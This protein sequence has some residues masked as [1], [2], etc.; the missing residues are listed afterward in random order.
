MSS[1]TA[2]LESSQ[3]TTLFAHARRVTRISLGFAGLS[4]LALGCSSASTEDAENTSSALGTIVPMGVS[5][6]TLS[7]ESPAGQITNGNGGCLDLP[8]GNT[9][10]GT[11]L[12]IWQCNGNGLHQSWFVD[13]AGSIHYGGNPFKCIDFPAQDLVNGI[14]IN[15]TQ[16]QIWDCNG[17]AGPDQ[18]WRVGT[19]N[20]IQFANDLNKCVELRNGNSI[21]DTPVQVYDCNGTRGQSWK[22]VQGGPVEAF[23]LKNGNGGCLDLPGGVTTNGTLLQLWACDANGD[24]QSWYMDGKSALHFALYPSK[25]VDFP[26]QA[27]NNGY[28]LPLSQLQLWDCNGGTGPDQRMDVMTSHTIEVQ[29][30]PCVEGEYGYSTNGTPVDGFKCNG[31]TGQTWWPQS[32]SCATSAQGC[33]Y[34]QLSTT[35]ETAAYGNGNLV[36]WITLTADTAGNLAL[37]PVIENM[38]QIKA[39]DFWL[40]CTVNQFAVSMSGRIGQAPFTPPGLPFTAKYISPGPTT[41]NFASLPAVWSSVRSVWTPKMASLPNFTCKMTAD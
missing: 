29:D 28:W 25:C 33:G 38:S 3:A 36:A 21:N 40:T 23:Q 34:E 20:Q 30:G 8:N 18:V 31:G 22:L 24:N 10:N 7:Y 11:P 4:L 14:P 5:N 27:W 12:H 6:I 32:A 19:L 16:L 1:C 9:A 13:G 26:A 37:T 41:V 15:M 17:A 2:P 35:Y 39:D